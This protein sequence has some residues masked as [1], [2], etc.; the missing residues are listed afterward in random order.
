MGQTYGVDANKW[1]S[2][3][4]CVAVNWAGSLQPAITP[5]NPAWSR[6]CRWLRYS[7]VSINDILNRGFQGIDPCRHLIHW[8]WQSWDVARS[9]TDTWT[10]FGQEFAWTC[11]QIWSPVAPANFPPYW[12][13]ILLHSATA[14][15]KL[16]T[17]ESR[18]FVRAWNVIRC[19]CT[20]LWWHL[21]LGC[22]RGFI[23]IKICRF[24]GRSRYL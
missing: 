17:H 11:H 24:W 3:P 12:K 10:H 22:N 14:S 13:Y 8:S 19:D 7:D 2:A 21:L 6:R 5:S 18:Q 1:T 20:Q 15:T 9:M 23:F 4:R 16:R